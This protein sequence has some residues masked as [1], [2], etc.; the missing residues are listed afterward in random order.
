MIAML[1]SKCKREL[2]IDLSESTTDHLKNSKI[3][4]VFVHG[5]EDA[6][7]PVEDAKR[8]YD[9]CAAPKELILVDGCGH[10]T[11]AVKG[12]APQRI[13]NFIKNYF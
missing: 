2:N 11:A 3:P 7:V 5:T 6:S 8:N 4:T 9:A 12:A 10:T 13:Y 1:R